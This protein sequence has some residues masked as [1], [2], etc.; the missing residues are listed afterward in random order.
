MN[1]LSRTGC[2]SYQQPFHCGSRALRARDPRNQRS[3]SDW[4]KVL[5]MG[6]VR[7]WKTV[8]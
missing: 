4:L 1:P 6:L 2:C 3:P 8:R 5:T 7:Y